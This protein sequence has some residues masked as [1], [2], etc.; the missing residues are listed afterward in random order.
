MINFQSGK[1]LIIF[2]S[3]PVSSSSKLVMAGRCGRIS[4][5]ASLSFDPTNKISSFFNSP[6]LMLLQVDL[7]NSLHCRFSSTKVLQFPLS[8]LQISGAQSSSK[9]IS[10]NLSVTR[11]VKEV[12]H[13]QNLDKCFE[14]I[15]FSRLSICIVSLLHVSALSSSSTLLLVSPKRRR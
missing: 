9:C 2:S 13:L 15:T 1:G 14:R 11:D 6:Q 5:R 10:C 12:R 7:P 3:P 8:V 4:V